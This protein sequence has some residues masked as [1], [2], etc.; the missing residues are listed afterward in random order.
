M[1][2]LLS[3]TNV[4]VDARGIARMLH[5]SPRTIWT[6]LSSGKLPAP[7]HRLSKRTVRWSRELIE[8]WITL[9]CPT[10]DRFAAVCHDTGTDGD[11]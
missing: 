4:L 10:A 2:K 8:R 1:N 7:T 5:V 11:R 6:L 9:G 3:S